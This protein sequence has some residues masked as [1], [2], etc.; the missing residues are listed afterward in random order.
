MLGQVV[1]KFSKSTTTSKCLLKNLADEF[2]KMKGAKIILH[3]KLPTFRATKLK[4][5]IVSENSF[6]I[7]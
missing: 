6:G 4:C 7:N 1:C 2:A 5:F 3:V